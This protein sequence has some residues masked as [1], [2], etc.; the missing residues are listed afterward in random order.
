MDA[1]DTFF[2][3]AVGDLVEQIVTAEATLASTG[4]DSD[5]RRICHSIKGSGG[6]FGFPLVS[7]LAAAAESASLDD[8]GQAVAM[9]K[10]ELSTIASTTDRKR[11]LVVDDDP[12]ICHL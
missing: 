1:L 5:L 9:L 2:R 6:S 11:I 7:S 10:A 8:L 12:L 4:D 3:E